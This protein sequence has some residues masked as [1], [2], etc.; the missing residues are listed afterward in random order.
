MTVSIGF[1]LSKY[2]SHRQKFAIEAF[3]K[4]EAERQEQMRIQQEMLARRKNKGTM[5]KYFE[6]VEERRKQ[7]A[8]DVGKNNWREGNVDPLNKWKDAMAKGDVK[9]IGYEPAPS[10]EES[11]TGFN[12]VVPVNPIGIPK[13]DEGERFDLRLPYAER[14]YE[15]PDADVLGKL[16]KGISN[17]FGMGKKAK[18]DKVN[19]KDKPT[20]KK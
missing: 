10:R 5:K 13:F 14:G 7:T 11:V 6:S 12:L 4:K 16:S 20:K 15:D 9:K 18:S 1:L 17:L 2:P 19:S 3:D 8:K